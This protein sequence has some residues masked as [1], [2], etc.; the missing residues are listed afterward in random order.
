MVEAL[1][2]YNIKQNNTVSKQ[3]LDEDFTFKYKLC[4]SSLIVKTLFKPWTTSISG[5]M[6]L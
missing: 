6:F 4:R 1:Q 2:Y 5:A 3:I